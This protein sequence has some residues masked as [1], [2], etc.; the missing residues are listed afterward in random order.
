M[1]LQVNVYTVNTFNFSM[2]RQDTSGPLT[3]KNSKYPDGTTID[4]KWTVREFLSSVLTL[5]GVLK[6]MWEVN[7]YYLVVD[8]QLYYVTGTDTLASLL[9]HRASTEVVRFFIYKL[10]KKVQF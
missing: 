8:Y 10:Q 7:N 5:Q 2:A 4:T 1:A 9:N 3:P 6:N